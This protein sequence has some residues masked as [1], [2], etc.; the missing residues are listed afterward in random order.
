[1]NVFVFKVIGF[2]SFEVFILIKSFFGF[3]GLLFIIIGIN[4][5]GLFI[6]VGFVIGIKVRF[7]V[8]FFVLYMR[9]GSE[10]VFRFGDGVGERVN[11]VDVGCNFCFVYVD[12][13][14]VDV[15]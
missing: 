3:C 8:V 4:S 5:F 14:Y 6:D 13:W 7:W 2:D 15:V 9:R 11:V 12:Y 10:E 1:M